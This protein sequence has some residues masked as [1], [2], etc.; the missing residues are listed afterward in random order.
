VPTPDWK[1]DYCNIERLSPDEIRQRRAHF[2]KQKEL[3][4]GCGK[5]RASPRPRMSARHRRRFL[6][7]VVGL[8]T[9]AR[10]RHA[11]IAETG[12]AA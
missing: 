3:A 2:D 4:Q 5:W 8:G 10:P 6:I 1:L 7:C 12:M 11:G 9:P